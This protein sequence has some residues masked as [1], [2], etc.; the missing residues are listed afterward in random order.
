MSS[1]SNI[2]AM[3]NYSEESM[4]GEPIL[5]KQAEVVQ[6][7]SSSEVDGLAW[8]YA[9]QWSNSSLDAFSIL[10]P[11]VV[12]GSSAEPIDSDD[13]SARLFQSPRSTWEMTCKDGWEAR[14]S[15]ISVRS[16]AISACYPMLT[17]TPYS[18]SRS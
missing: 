16:L 7:S 10:I 13:A 14:A 3:R 8:D 1:L 6:A 2:M 18:V 5:E 12:G 4:R 15:R 11:G 9:M 17:A